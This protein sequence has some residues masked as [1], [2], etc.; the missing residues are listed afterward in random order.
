MNQNKKI[1]KS[2]GNLVEVCSRYLLPKTRFNPIKFNK[3]ESYLPYGLGRSY[4]DICLPENSVVIQ[5]S[6]LNHFIDFNEKLGVLE[7]EAGV[8][9]DEI[10]KISVPRGW[11]L[12][13]TPGTKYVTI[14]GAIANDVH[15][16][17][18]HKV[19]SFGHFLKQFTIL[20]SDGKLYGCTE[21]ENKDLFKATI[22]G[23]GLTGL[24][25]SAKIQLIKIE[26]SKIDVTSI[27]FFNLDE[28]IELNSKYKN[29]TYSVAWYDCFTQRGHFIIGEHSKEGRL[30]IHKE[31][32]INIPFNFPSL[33]LNSLTIRIFNF[34]YFHRQ[35]GNIKKIKQHYNEFFYP[36]DSIYN[37]NRIYGKKGFYQYQCVLP[38]NKKENFQLILDL[39]TKSK[40]GSFLC[41]VKSF[42][43]HKNIGDL[44]FP[45]NGLTLCLDFKN[46]GKETVELFKLIDEVVK[47]SGG[48]IYPA[49]DF[50]MTGEDFH[51]Y[52]K[53]NLEHYINNLDQQFKSM[54]SKRLSIHSLEKK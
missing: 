16:K 39:I 20:R 36:L 23:L 41:V 35:I 31:P 33:L 2:W 24:I 19:G 9:L 8:T 21:V 13:V 40:Q 50:N 6:D 32:S 29:S 5:T 18:H 44:S 3:D 51:F 7:V 25:I 34:L 52:Y 11:F 54:M 27:K 26:S 47:E 10:L 42:G 17:N 37:W 30:E 43:N 4:G 22:G 53:D 15:G 14:G 45:M 28:L 12:P 48:R 46:L 1:F 38:F 49:K